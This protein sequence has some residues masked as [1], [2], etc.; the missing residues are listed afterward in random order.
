MKDALK[1]IKSDS[2]FV[3][4]GGGIKIWGNVF[5]I[6]RKA[7]SCLGPGGLGEQ[8][9]ERDA[10]KGQTLSS[11]PPRGLS[12]RRACYVPGGSMWTLHREARLL[13]FPFR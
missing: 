3:G 9:E 11:S 6:S 13:G 5:E 10:S 4:E 7:T 8:R 2:T 1:I 12:C